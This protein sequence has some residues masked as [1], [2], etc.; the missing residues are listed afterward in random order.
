LWLV[1]FGV[2]QDATLA[3]DV[4]QEA[5]LV[6]LSKFGEFR[7][8]SNYTAWMAKIV[9][10]VARNQA[11]SRRRRRLVSLQSAAGQIAT[12]QGGTA[13]H[14][15]SALAALAADQPHFDDR[16]MAALRRVADVPRMCLLLRT[17]EGMEY[18]EIARLLGIPAGTAMSHVHRTRQ[19]LRQELAD[20]RPV[21]SEERPAPS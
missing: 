12:D 20:L 15:R 16:M 6:A 5:A 17:I 8:G 18:A 14:S 2:V 7:P 21:G 10:F 1:A 9:Q 3:E 4:V 13:D 19:F 11:R